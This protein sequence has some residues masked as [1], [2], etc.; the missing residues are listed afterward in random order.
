MAVS[1]LSLIQN[2]PWLIF[3][4]GIAVLVIVMTNFIMNV[5][6]IAITLPVAL[7][8]AQY[9]GVN[10]QLILYVATA[11]AGMPMLLLMGAAPNAIAYDYGC[12]PGHRVGPG[13]AFK[14][15][16]Q[17][18]YQGKSTGS[19]PVQARVRMKAGFTPALFIFP[20]LLRCRP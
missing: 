12:H 20:A 5:A 11:A 14:A 18:A 2:A 1:W 6:A 4:L 17:G 15:G 7:V 8:I 10:P 13:L 16:Y 19:G 9:L 3:V